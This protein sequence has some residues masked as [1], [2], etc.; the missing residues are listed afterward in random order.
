MFRSMSALTFVMLTSLAFPD[1]AEDRRLPIPPQAE[2]D[3]AAQ[4]VKEVFKADFARTKATDRIALAGRLIE[5]AD[6]SKD[7]PASR[8]ALLGQARELSAKGGDAILFLASARKMASDFR[9]TMREACGSDSPAPALAAAAAPSREQV[10]A[11]VDLVDIAIDEGDFVRA[12]TFMTGVEGI[13]RKT[14]VAE[15]LAAAQL[16]SKSLPGLRIA[17]AD[18]AK[19]R[20]TLESNPT[21][22]EANRLV[23]RFD[24]LVRERWDEG[25]AHLLLGDDPKLRDAVAKDVQAATGTAKNQAD[26]AEAW[27]KAS[28]GLDSLQKANLDRRAL[29]WLDKAIPNLSGLEKSLA[30]SRMRELAKAVPTPKAGPTP[31]ASA[32]PTAVPSLEGTVWAGTDSSAGITTFHF[33][34]GGA[35]VYSHSGKTYRNATWKQDGSQLYFEMNQKFRECKATVNGDSIEGNSWNVKGKMWQTSLKKQS[36]AK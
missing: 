21:D 7:E 22:A 33:E 35:L 20:K 17:Y 32:D 28:L 9:V 34:K 29:Y 11:L 13:A 3:A 19:L 24:C 18:L 10:Q 1:G 15:L 31:K 2:L 23:G 30:D 27:Q 14:K 5:L 4:K 16:R 8:F 36:N 6:Q 26:A 12:A 25:L